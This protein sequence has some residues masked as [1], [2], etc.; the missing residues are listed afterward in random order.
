M[1]NYFCETPTSQKKSLFCN[2]GLADRH[3]IKHNIEAGSCQ[4]TPLHKRRDKVE[5]LLQ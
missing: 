3:I 5:E 1:I 2:D 4:A